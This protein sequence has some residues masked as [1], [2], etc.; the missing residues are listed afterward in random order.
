MVLRGTDGRLTPHGRPL[1]VF[2]SGDP[3][4]DTLM[5]KSLLNGFALEG[6]P[7]R[8]GAEEFFP[9]LEMTVKSFAGPHPTGKSTNTTVGERFMEVITGALSGGARLDQAVMEHRQ[10]VKTFERNQVEYPYNL[11]RDFEESPSPASVQGSRGAG[12]LQTEEP[13]QLM[14]HTGEGLSLIHI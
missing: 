9:F 2:F 13:P 10:E 8:V 7:G 14:R 11:L 3:Q 1:G 6:Q 4:T 12:G 5:P